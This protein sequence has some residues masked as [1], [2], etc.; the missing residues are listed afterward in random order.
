MIQKY[1]ILDNL[2]NEIDIVNTIEEAN[3]YIQMYKDINPHL[4]LRY[5][6]FEYSTVKSGFGR[7]PDLH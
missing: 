1:K 2:D 3:Q 6:S 4:E 7:D 5:E